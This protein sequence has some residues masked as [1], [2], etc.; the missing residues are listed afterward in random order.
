MR[1]GTEATKHEQ[2]VQVLRR[3]ILGGE[4]APGTRLRQQAIARW[5][6]VSA[7]PVREA[8]CI[9]LAEGLLV[10]VSNKGFFVA[11]RAAAGQ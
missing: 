11:E 6:G 2:S 1:A 9:L 3:A 10:H 8:M 5:L 7:T 4:L